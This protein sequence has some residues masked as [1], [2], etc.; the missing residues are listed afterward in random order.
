MNIKLGGTFVEVLVCLAVF[1]EKNR[2]TGRNDHM[3]QLADETEGIFRRRS[4]TETDT[5]VSAKDQ[6][7]QRTNL[8]N[9]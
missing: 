5:D 7:N 9:D 2:S 1:R 3:N 6:T 8:L 4:Y